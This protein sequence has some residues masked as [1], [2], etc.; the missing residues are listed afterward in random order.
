MNLQAFLNSQPTEIYQDVLVDG[1]VAY[2]GVRDCESRYALIRPVLEKYRRPFTVLDLGANLGYFGLSILRDFPDA[3]VVAVE[4]EY[5]PLLLDILSRQKADRLILLDH[6]IST[7]DIHLLA[8]V[9]HFDVTLAL[10]FIHHLDTQPQESFEALER[11]GDHLIIETPTESRA[12]GQD[13][14]Q[15]IR[16]PDDA[17]FLGETTSHLAGV[18]PIHQISRIKTSLRKAYIGS[19]IACKVHIDSNYQNKT[20]T[21]PDGRSSPYGRGINLL[22]FRHFNGRLPTWDT[23][24]SQLKEPSTRHGDIFQHNVILSGDDTY[25]IDYDHHPSSRFDDSA[26]WNKL[27]REIE[28]LNHE[29]P[30]QFH[31][32]PA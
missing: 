6:R 12:C 17:K 31:A 11:L 2:E 16:L 26:H 14:V 28:T 32:G 22:T 18:R 1:R 8:D 9:E 5:T 4:S 20:V 13:K 15:A 7:G 3:T 21:R 10:S 24:Y 29:N 25:L 19:P 23:V 27:L 30:S